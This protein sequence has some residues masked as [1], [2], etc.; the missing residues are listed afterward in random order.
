MIKNFILILLSTFLVNT[1]STIIQYNFHNNN[2]PETDKCIRDAMEEIMD[3]TCLIFEENPSN[4]DALFFIE[5]GHCSW[6]AVNKTVHLGVDCINS[7][8][9]Q[10]IITRALTNDRPYPI[11]SR[12]LNIK[13]NCTDKCTLICENGGQVNGNCECECAYGFKGDR[14]EQL[15]ME[16][17]FTDTT[18]GFIDDESSGT[19]SLSTYPGFINK[20]PTFCQWVIKAENPWENIEFEIV[21]IDLANENLAP[22]QRCEDSLV[23]VGIESLTGPIPCDEGKAAIIGK[24]FR[25]DG[26]FVLIELKTSSWSD[27]KY[28]GPQI[29]FRTHKRSLFDNI[30][31]LTSEITSNSGFIYSTTKTLIF[32]SLTFVLSQYFV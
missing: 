25:S 8:T 32:I 16:H 14:C 31:I 15:K 29:K 7:K 18:C 1:F 19:V 11:A 2:S 26:N 13:Y 24:T 10:D 22:G 12:V 20:K 30:K 9:C 4:P 5:S 27:G 17:M 23:V 28:K 3:D 6:Q 21:D